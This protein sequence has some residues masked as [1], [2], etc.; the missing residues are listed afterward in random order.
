METPYQQ[1]KRNELNQLIA[2]THLKAA[3]YESSERAGEVEASLDLRD[4]ALHVGSRQGLGEIGERQR[5][6]E[7][8][9]NTKISTW[10]SKPANASGANTG[11]FIGLQY[12]FMFENVKSI[13]EISQKSFTG[14]HFLGGKMLAGE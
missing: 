1:H 13:K 12:T 8:L 9:G 11:H 2:G 4:G 7:Q 3:I 10:S 14:P 5:H 6:Y